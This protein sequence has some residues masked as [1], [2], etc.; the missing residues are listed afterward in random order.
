MLANKADDL[1]FR[2]KRAPGFIAGKTPREAIAE[3]IRLTNAALKSRL[4]V[5]AVGFRTPG[6]FA[7][8]LGDRP[9]VQ[10]LLLDLG[11]S[12]VSS[13]YPTH[14]V[15]PPLQ[16]PTQEIIDAIVKVQQQAQPY[17]YPTGLVEVPMSP[18]SD[19]GAFRN[20]RWKL[21][22]FL[23]A[24][25]C[26]VEWA[27]ERRAVFDFLGHPSCLYVT[28]PEFRTIELI[29]DLVKKAGPRATLVDLQALAKRGGGWSWPLF[30]QPTVSLRSTID[31]YAY[32]CRRETGGPHPDWIEDLASFRRWSAD[33]EFPDQGRICFLKGEVWVDMSK[34][35][36]FTHNQVKNEYSFVLTGIVKTAQRGF[37]F[38]DGVRL[39]NLPADI[40]VRPD[41][42]F[43]SHESL[44]LGRV[45]WVEGAQEGFVEIEGSPDMTLEVVSASSVEK[46]TVDLRDFYWQAGVQEYWLVDARAPRPVF[47]ILRHTGRGY[48]SV[49]KQDGW[50]RSTVFGRSFR[51]TRK[52][53]AE[54]CPQFTLPR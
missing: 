36:L 14:P 34:E 12:W 5:E 15:G 40:S 20:G 29:C 45:R 38:P 39:V 10:R 24:I 18:I 51:L 42:L 2:F 17:V 52:N 37:F 47:E 28:D 44:Q 35:Q 9:D 48:V 4:G 31:N 54:G 50:I 22:W 32:V 30:L 6:G 21:D 26:A 7:N 23:K 49:R 43:V 8:G 46:D 27:I 3:N 13:K 41:A 53:G 33:E 11:F 25:R 16:E 1:Q 19:I